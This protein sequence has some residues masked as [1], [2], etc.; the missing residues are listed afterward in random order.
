MKKNLL[1][2]F[3]LGLGLSSFA[4]IT[5]NNINDVTLTPTVGRETLDIDM[6]GN[7]SID[8]RVFALD[9]SVQSQFG[10]VPVD[11]IGIDLIGNNQIDGS[12]QSTG[13]GDILS[14]KVYNAAE[15]INSSSNFMSGNPSNFVDGGGL[16]IGTSF[17]NAG[18]FVDE[19]DKYIAVKFEIGTS[20]PTTHYGWIRVDVADDAASVTVKD[21]AYETAADTQIKAGDNGTTIIG[22]SISEKELANA[23]VFYGNNELNVQGITGSYNVSVVDLLGKSISNTK[24]NNN[25]TINLNNVNNG[26]YLVQVTKGNSVVTKKVYIK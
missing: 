24:V 17:G 10:A 8:F 3:A 22:T 18:D 21:F 9:T 1:S 6:D 7:G 26:I 19:T 4:Q 14:V 5:Y 12:Q 2:I 16:G 13:A 15:D 11:A 23:V 25:A 20:I